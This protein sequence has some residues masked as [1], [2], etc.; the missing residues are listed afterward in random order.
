MIDRYKKVLFGAALVAAGIS[1]SGRGPLRGWA[2]PAE[3]VVVQEMGFGF[4]AD[5][6]RPVSTAFAGKPI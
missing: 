1:G 2:L 4:P 6:V 3:A 5:V